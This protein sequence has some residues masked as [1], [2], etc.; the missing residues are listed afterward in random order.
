MSSATAAITNYA[1]VYY[2]LSKYKAVKLSMKTTTTTRVRYVNH[3]LLGEPY[4]YCLK[5]GE[6]LK[7]SEEG[8]LEYVY[9][10]RKLV[11]PLFYCV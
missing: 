8:A 10:P 4:T 11:L 1:I 7:L 2:I 3:K 6:K 9:T 5:N